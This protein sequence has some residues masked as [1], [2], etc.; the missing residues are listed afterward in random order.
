[1]AEQEYGS[2][3]I[4]NLSALLFQFITPRAVTRGKSINFVLSLVKI[5]DF[6]LVLLYSIK[7]S[8][9]GLKDQRKAD[10]EDKSLK[11]QTKVYV[12]GG[13][14]F[15]FCPATFIIRQPSVYA[16]ICRFYKSGLLEAQAAKR[17]FY[18]DVAELADALD[19]GSSEVTLMQVQ[20]LSSAPNAH[21]PNRLTIFM[22]GE[23]FG[24][25]LFYEYPNSNQ[26]KNKG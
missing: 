1:M 8:V 2:I 11:H 17:I 18:A 16:Q 20:V 6:L 12:A 24:F 7:A 10:G 26:K 3:T 23:S 13:G 9:A 21:N 25:L 5:L 19:S 4:F 14:N 22:V 15:A